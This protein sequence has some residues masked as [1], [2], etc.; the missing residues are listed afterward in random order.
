MAYSTGTAS[1]ASNLISAIAGFAS[2]LG[3]STSGSA[4]SI[5]I[6]KGGVVAAFSSPSSGDVQIAWNGSP[7]FSGT[8]HA[9]VGSWPADYYLFGNVSPDPDQIICIINYDAIDYRY[10]GFG[11]ISKFGSWTGGEWFGASSKTLDPNQNLSMVT[12]NLTGRLGGT[13]AFGIE[14]AAVGPQTGAYLQSAIDGAGWISSEFFESP[15][16]QMSRVNHRLFQAQPN[17]WNQQAV[18]LPWLLAQSRPD[19]LFSL[20][21]E[22]SNV[23]FLR[24]D[25]LNPGDVITLG[26]D[27]WQCFPILRKDSIVRNGSDVNYGSGTFGWAF[28]K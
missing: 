14:G 25:N 20:I 19:G 21:G 10:V 13:G 8:A 24:I 5:E 15:Y 9:F 3:W 27:D 1:S 6:S 2:G 4:P 22:L 28:K 23:R 26:S 12:G 16:F 11:L 7:S 17:A 18:L